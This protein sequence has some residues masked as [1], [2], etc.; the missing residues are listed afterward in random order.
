MKKNQSPR[1]ICFERII[2]DEIDLDATAR[3]AAF[4]AI[5]ESLDTPLDPSVATFGRRMAVSNA[6][7]WPK[8]ITLKCR[9]LEG[10]AKLRKAVAKAASEWE[11]HANI[12]FKF[13]TSGPA[14]IRIAFMD[15]GSWSAVGKDCLNTSY[16][17]KH[18]PT[19]NYGW[20]DDDSSKEEIASVVLH[21]FGHALGCLHEHQSPTFD[22]AWNVKKV[23]Q[24]FSGSPNYWDEATIRHN[25]LQ[26]YSPNGT[27]ATRFDPK[28]I[29]LYMFQ[30][31]LFTD[32][33]GPTNENHVL[34]PLD[35]KMIAR[36]YPKK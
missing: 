2:P 18:Q 17:P 26:K 21:E 14:E 4:E 23:I 11:N 8:G 27:S 31:D 28:S 9:F 5:D 36:M 7:K 3:R 19:M 15:D 34:S 13:V 33:L 1:R 35:K 12:D 22:R 25:V 20:L 30:A 16:F 6:K 24:S 32:G 29:M 10:S